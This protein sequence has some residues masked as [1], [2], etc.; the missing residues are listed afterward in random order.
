[1]SEGRGMDEE[2]PC[3]H[4]HSMD[5]PLLPSLLPRRSMVRPQPWLMLVEMLAQM[6][7]V[8]DPWARSEGDV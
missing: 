8:G 7:A 5:A 2:N 4:Q 1:M 6:P 3:R